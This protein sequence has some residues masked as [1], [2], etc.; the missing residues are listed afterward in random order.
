MT[1]A[2]KVKEALPTSE[3][4]ART[5]YDASRSRAGLVPISNERWGDFY[6]SGLQETLALRWQADAVHNLLLDAAPSPAALDPDLAGFL[7]TQA[8]AEK[9]NGSGLWELLEEAAEAIETLSQ[10]PAALDPLADET[11]SNETQLREA[12]LAA[13]EWILSNT[14]GENDSSDSTM[15]ERGWWDRDT[16]L[17]AQIDRALLAQPACNAREAVLRKFETQEGFNLIIND[18]WALHFPKEAESNLDFLIAK[19]NAVTSTDRTQS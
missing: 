18:K 2:M 12:L 13:R 15:Y 10:K 4:I 16:K 9:A 17:M 11:M 3:E 14:S 7:R 6:D 5:L 8:K 1:D 19:V